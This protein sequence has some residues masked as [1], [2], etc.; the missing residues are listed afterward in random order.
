MKEIDSFDRA[1]NETRIFV[2]L[3]T[4]GPTAIVLRTHNRELGDRQRILFSP[5][6]AK[7]AGEALLAAAARTEED[8]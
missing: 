6:E 1:D 2:E 4:A 3:T 7:R 8:D 5:D